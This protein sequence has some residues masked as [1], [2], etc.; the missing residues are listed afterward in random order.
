[1]SMPQTLTRTWAKQESKIP[2]MAACSL[3]FPPW[4]LDPVP[5]YLDREA[6]LCER[7]E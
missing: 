6:H 5:Y 4:P 7:R 2:A 1:M 3:L